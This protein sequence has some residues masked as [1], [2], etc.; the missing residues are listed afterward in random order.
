MESDE[1]HFQELQQN[2]N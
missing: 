2:K 1:N